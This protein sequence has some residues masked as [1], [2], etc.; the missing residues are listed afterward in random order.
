MAPGLVPQLAT[1]TPW[2]I[3]SPSRFRT[4]GPPAMISDQYTADF[5][6]VEASDKATG[7]Q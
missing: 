7:C 5:N 6:E 2:I 4:A 3:S 1:T